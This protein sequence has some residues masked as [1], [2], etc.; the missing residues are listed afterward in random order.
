MASAST[1][2]RQDSCPGSLAPE[3]P[4]VHLELSVDGERVSSGEREKSMEAQWTLT[5]ETLLPE[6]ISSARGLGRPQG[7]LSTGCARG[8]WSH[9]SSLEEERREQARGSGR[10]SGHALRPGVK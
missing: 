7:A 9:P 4:A 10:W 8:P 3:L 5:F 1:V 6:T 2:T